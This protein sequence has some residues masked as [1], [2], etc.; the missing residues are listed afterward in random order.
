[1]RLVKSVRPTFRLCRVVMLPPEVPRR[2]PLQR[3]GYRI[4]LR[5][6]ALYLP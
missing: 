6:T 4:R 3:H 2:L 5:R 1:M